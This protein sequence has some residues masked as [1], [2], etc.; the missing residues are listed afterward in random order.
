LKGADVLLLVEAFDENR[1]ADV[2]LSVSSKSHLYMFSRRPIIV[3]SH[4]D[5]G[6]SKYAS[7]YGWAKV[8]TERDVHALYEVMHAFAR[9]ADERDRF[10]SRAAEIAL[11]MHSKMQMQERFLEALNA[12]LFVSH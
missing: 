5:T 6:V 4:R 7:E 1:V 9:D 3:Y 10:V 8:V 2:H 12:S 11:S